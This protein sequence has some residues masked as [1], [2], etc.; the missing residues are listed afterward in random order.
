MGDRELS[1]PSTNASLCVSLIGEDCRVQ[2][3]GT[4]SSVCSMLRALFGATFAGH[5]LDG[6]EPTAF[7]GRQV[8]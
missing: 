4:V 3:C 8:Q 1:Q 6:F 2:E 7:F 5:S